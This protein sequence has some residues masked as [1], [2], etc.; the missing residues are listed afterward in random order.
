MVSHTSSSSAFS[1]PLLLSLKQPTLGNIFMLS[2]LRIKNFV[3]NY[4]L[5]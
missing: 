5:Y 1:S 2:S 3:M 4:G